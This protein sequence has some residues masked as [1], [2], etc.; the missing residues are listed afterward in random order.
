MAPYVYQPLNLPHET[1]ILTLLPGRE[2]EE[3]LCSLSHVRF[4]SDETYEA[5]SYCWGG[6]AAH[7]LDLDTPVPVADTASNSVRLPIVRDLLRDEDNGYLYIKFGG[8][9]PGGTIVCDQSELAIGGELF[10]ALQNIRDTE[11]PLRIWIDA[12]CI[13]QQDIHERTEHVKIMGNI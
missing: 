10:R 4:A 11:T 8:P 7:M 1:R 13:N 2:D 3:V 6:S 9:L 12:I 5:L